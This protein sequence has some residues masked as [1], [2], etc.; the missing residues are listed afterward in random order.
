MGRSDLTVVINLNIAV[1]EAVNFFWHGKKEKTLFTVCKG[2]A[3]TSS[4]N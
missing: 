2:Q 4:Q 1:P 3:S